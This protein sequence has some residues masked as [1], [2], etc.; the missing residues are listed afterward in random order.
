MVAWNSMGLGANCDVQ[1]CKREVLVQH[2]KDSREKP[3]HIWSKVIAKWVATS[4]VLSLILSPTRIALGSGPSL[5]LNESDWAER[6]VP[7]ATPVLTEWLRQFGTNSSESAYGLA[8]AATGVYIIGHTGGIFPSQS[9]VGLQDA[10]LRYHDKSGNEVWTRQFGTSTMDEALDIELDGTGIYIVGSTYGIL[11]GQSNSG[12]QDAYVRCHDASGNE[13]WTRQFGSSD[14]E[15]ATA[16]AVD[17]TG[18]YVG[19]STYGVIPGQSSAGFLDAFVRKYDGDGNI[20]WTRQFGSADYDHVYG[21]ALDGSG[22][23][24][25]GWTHGILPGQD[26]FGQ[27]D[28]Y[29]RK[30][31]GDG[32][33]V[34]TR[35]FGTSDYDVVSSLTSDAT[36]VYAAGWTWGTL[37]GQSNAGG[38]DAYVRKYDASGEEVW[39]HQ[40]GSPGTDYANALTIDTTGVYIAGYTGAA[41]AGQ[42]WA[43]AGDIFLH[44][45]D[46]NGNGRWTYQLGTAAEDAAT[47]LGVDTS[48]IYLAGFT[49][50]T[51][52]GNSSE[53]P[54]DAFIAKVQQGT[55]SQLYLPKLEQ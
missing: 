51:F 5:L 55:I 40:F 33:E 17:A 26:T 25:G 19:G 9:S 44:N 43:G 4:F 41:L 3:R 13:L 2:E 54:L 6:A 36:G 23:Y 7:D 11:P 10:Y 18:I 45:V 39:T 37:P 15:T 30:Y 21:L 52:P 14:T 29:I 50:A 35:Q 32:N 46:S 12:Y 27:Y 53:G 28:A 31:D 48:G 22:V 1:R 8:V 16:V 47:A 38:R 42:S 34:W 24:V 20:M 49:G